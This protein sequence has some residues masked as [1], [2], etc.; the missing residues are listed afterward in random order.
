MRTSRSRRSIPP[1]RGR[2]RPKRP[3]AT[4]RAPARKPVAEPSRFTHR[5]G[6]LCWCSG[7]ICGIL[8]RSSVSCSGGHGARGRGLLRWAIH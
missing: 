6:D 5:A 1:P 2:H 4:T 7:P 8:Q 3:P